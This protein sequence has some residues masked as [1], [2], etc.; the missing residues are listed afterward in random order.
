MLIHVGSE[1]KVTGKL[2]ITIFGKTAKVRVFFKF[3]LIHLKGSKKDNTY[4]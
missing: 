2:S 3:S 4:Q 1:K